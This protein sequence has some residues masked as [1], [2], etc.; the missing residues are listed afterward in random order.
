MS[1]A[2]YY[3]DKALAELQ[4]WK[5]LLL[6]LLRF[7]SVFLILCLLFAPL[8]KTKKKI[9]EKPIIV[10]ALDNSASVSRNTDSLYYSRQYAN[11]IRNLMSDLS[12]D[13]QVYQYNFGEQMRQDSIIDFS[14]K[15]T[16]MSEIFPMIRAAHSG[17]NL[18]AVIVAGDGI[19]NVGENPVYSTDIGTTVYTIALGDTVRSKDVFI[20]QVQHNK[21]AF[22][23]NS[24]PVRIIVEAVQCNNEKIRI[25]VLNVN[26]KLFEKEII[27]YE[28]D[29]IEKIELELPA[30]SKGL[31]QYEV[32]IDRIEG[33]ISTE[34]N[35]QSFVVEVIDNK[36]NILILGNSPHPDI[37]AIAYALKSNPDYQISV[38][39]AGTVTESMNKYQLIILHQVPSVN[40][41]AGNIL[42]QISR[43]KIPCIYILG[44]KTSLDALN[45]TQSGLKITAAKSS[46]D[47][48]TPLFQSS[49]SAYSNDQ[50]WIDIVSSLPPLVVPFGEYSFTGAGRKLMTQ[51]INAVTT[52]R[53]LIAFSDNGSSKNGFITGEGIWRWRME[54]YRQSGSH[55]LFNQFVN[56]M[57]QYMITTH[58][59][60]SLVVDSKRVFNENEPV[61]IEA[62]FYDEAFELNNTSE[63]YATITDEKGRILK[64]LFSR[65][66]NYYTLNLG[67][68]P[69]GRYS[70]E[71]A[72]EFDTKT[73][74]ASA[75]FIVVE[76]NLEQLSSMADHSMLF[77][78]AVENGGKM[79]YPNQ[80]GTLNGLIRSDKNIVTNMF[81][82]IKLSNLIDLKILFF[83]ILF[84]LSLEWFLRK[85]W[86]V[87]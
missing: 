76:I 32:V 57:V 46:F 28:D 13:Y 16:D 78:L 53:P 41:P 21:V 31:Q 45:L 80:I 22:Y 62:E 42:N 37:G 82:Q 43:N 6:A 58:D 34:N 85:F 54:A 20:K 18:G 9:I 84:L 19:F 77:K 59:K 50:E 63:L 10:F 30:S 8:L 26:E 40:N 67:S 86:G 7:L 75:E 24:F 4:K 87:Y 11:D 55:Q 29:C 68:L 81:E 23:K 49:F 47:E 79:V 39:Y 70:Y 65:N 64:K 2:L 44:A 35:R 56:K 27:A 15:A 14:D 17:R 69:P 12:T 73:Y 25:R 51:K 72:L 38:Q 3:R 74:S 66:D 1:M 5:I 71:A 60:Q 83:I 33:E 61:I 36:Q 52:N 48:A